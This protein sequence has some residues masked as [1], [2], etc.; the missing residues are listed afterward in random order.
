M[1]LGTIA[2]LTAIGLATWAAS[3]DEKSDLEAKIRDLETQAAKLLEDGRTEAALECVIEAQKLRD[4][5]EALNRA[6]KAARAKDAAPAK[7]AARKPEPK[8]PKPNPRMGSPREQS[9]SGLARKHLRQAQE[10]LETQ[11]PR[12]AIEHGHAAMANLG[13][14]EKELHVREN[15]LKL[16]MKRAET[17]GNGQAEAA[18]RRLMERLERLEVQVRKLREA[19]K[20]QV[21]QKPR[22][23]A[24]PQ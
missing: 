24:G 7:S 17:G 9:A 5:A 3:A 16:A 15:R 14:W 6:K 23:P 18:E 20:S 1:R 19:L 10:A 12:V 8:Q 2:L 4:R 11:Q 21:A 13:R 22:R